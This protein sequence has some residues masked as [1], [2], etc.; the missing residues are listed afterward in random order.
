MTK[1][2]FSRR[3]IGLMGVIAA[4]AVLPV[5]AASADTSCQNPSLS[6]PFRSVGDQNW[7][8]LAPGESVDHFDA[9]NW[10]LSGGARLVTTKLADGT[11]GEVLDLPSGSKA[12][13]P[14]MCVDLGYQTI[15]TMVRNVVGAEGVFFSVAY[16]GTNTWGQPRNTGQV[17]GQ[18][19]GWTLSDPVN[20]QPSNTPGWQRVQFTFT[21]G[22]QRSDFQIYNF[23]VDPRMRG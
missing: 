20:V 21:P 9:T 23:Y 11:T 12:V 13:S 15:R 5:Q 8:T 18:Q 17:H 16:E 7:Y 6:Q 22:G 3:L 10:T 4:F 1:Y 2:L 14:I 19:T